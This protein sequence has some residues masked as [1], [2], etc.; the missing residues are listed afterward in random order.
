MNSLFLYFR[1]VPHPNDPQVTAYLQR[2]A[3]G[4]K[5]DKDKAAAGEKPFVL[6]QQALLQHCL[7]P[8][9]FL[10]EE[11]ALYC[12]RMSLLLHELETP[13][14][15]SLQVCFLMF[16]FFLLRTAFV[17]NKRCCCELHIFPNAHIYFLL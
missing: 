9:L 13:D 16:F 3:N 4:D 1:F 2:K 5:E 10:S 17:V 15:S 8:R 12:A 14:F 7:L 6:I 11:D